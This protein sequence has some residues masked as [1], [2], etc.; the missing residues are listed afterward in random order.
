M[1]LSVMQSNFLCLSYLNPLTFLPTCLFGLV[2]QSFSCHKAGNTCQICLL[3]KQDSD[4]F[5]KTTSD[6]SIKISYTIFDRENP[7][8]LWWVKFIKGQLATNEFYNIL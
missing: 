3:I 2:A 5:L 1:M 4:H 7:V 6:W 8:C